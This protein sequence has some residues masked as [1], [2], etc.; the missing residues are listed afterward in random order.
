MLAKGLRLVVKAL[1]GYQGRQRALLSF[2]DVF[3]DRVQGQLQHM[4]LSLLSRAPPTLVLVL[5]SLMTAASTIKK[6]LCMTAQL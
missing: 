3:V 2:Q 5:L 6:A 4:L 1:R